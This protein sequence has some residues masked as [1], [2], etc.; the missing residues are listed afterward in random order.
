MPGLIMHDGDVA[1]DEPI[2]ERGF[3]DIGPP[4]DGDFSS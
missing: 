1:A 4:D 3:A 2:E